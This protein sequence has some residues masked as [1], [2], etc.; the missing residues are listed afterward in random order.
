MRVSYP[1]ERSE[2]GSGEDTGPA[3]PPDHETV[4]ADGA[5]GKAYT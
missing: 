5:Y 4:T 3:S 2:P 1:N